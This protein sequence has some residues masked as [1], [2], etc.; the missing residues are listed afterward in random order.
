MEAY[1]KHDV[2]K[3]GAFMLKPN[4]KE[5][6]EKTAEAYR[7]TV[8][9]VMDKATRQLGIS[10][11]L[12]RSFVA[13]YLELISS[14]KSVYSKEETDN[15][16]LKKVLLDNIASRSGKMDSIMIERFF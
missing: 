2:N 9:S 6:M 3:D 15:L 13:E 10:M 14:N 1:R 11:E 8:P 4:V 7:V 12:F 5:A 16:T